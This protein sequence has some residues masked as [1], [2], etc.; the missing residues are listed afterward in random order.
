MLKVNITC[1][2]FKEKKKKFKA[3]KK[4]KLITKTH[5]LIEVQRRLLAATKTEGMDEKCTG[6]PFF[7]AYALLCFADIVFFHKLNICGNPTLSEDGKHFL[8]IKYF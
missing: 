2:Q 6:T 5:K 8:A 4:Q 7:I 1:F 3:R